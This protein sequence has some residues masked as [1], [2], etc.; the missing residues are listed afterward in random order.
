MLGKPIVKDMDE[1]RQRELKRVGELSQ[2]HFRKHAEE[3][4]DLKV[5]H[6]SLIRRQGGW[7]GVTL[8]PSFLPGKINKVK[9][10]EDHPLNKNPGYIS[11]EA[12]EMLILR[13][14]ISSQIRGRLNDL[15]YKVCDKPQFAK[16]KERLS[17]ILNNVN[18]DTPVQLREKLSKKESQKFFDEGIASMFARSRKGTDLNAPDSH[19][20]SEDK[21]KKLDEVLKTMRLTRTKALVE[22]NKAR[23]RQS[24]IMRRRKMSKKGPV[25]EKDFQRRLSLTNF[26]KGFHLRPR[27]ES[28]LLIDSVW[29]EEELLDLEPAEIA[30]GL[31]LNQRHTVA[32]HCD[33]TA[34]DRR[35]AIANEKFMKTIMALSVTR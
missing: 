5:N 21:Q 22:E 6:S 12:K 2:M 33:L 32:Q 13:G 19:M 23:Q 34:R 25:S 18:I 30:L 31:G 35:L 20:P 24:Q 28:Q 29:R 27:R 4:Y 8:H 14:V 1:I 11:S 9:D 17:L 10:D 3:A 16:E 26:G 15:I 7:R